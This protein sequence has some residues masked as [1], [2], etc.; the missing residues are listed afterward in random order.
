MT[1]TAICA[2]ATLRFLYGGAGTTEFHT[3]ADGVT[4]RST[5]HAGTRVR[6]SWLGT[7]KDDMAHVLGDDVCTLGYV[8]G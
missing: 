6:N 8:L 3:A 2:S 4:I 5:E 1:S 7:E